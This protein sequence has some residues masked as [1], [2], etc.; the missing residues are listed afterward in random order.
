MK[1][2]NAKEFMAKLCFIQMNTDTPCFYHVRDI[3][4]AQKKLNVKKLKF[5]WVADTGFK[6]D[7]IF[8]E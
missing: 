6:C 4:D 1:L 8:H 3:L 2:L 5:S 7:V